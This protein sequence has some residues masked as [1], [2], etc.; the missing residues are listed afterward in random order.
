MWRFGQVVEDCAGGERRWRLEQ[1]ARCG[2][3]LSW[4]SEVV[5]V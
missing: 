1:V 4:S 3:V 5:E 2:G